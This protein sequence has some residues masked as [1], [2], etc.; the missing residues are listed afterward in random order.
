MA[1]IVLRRS[2]GYTITV[3][4][5]RGFDVKDSRFQLTLTWY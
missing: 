2:S 5:M 4:L 3:L 1:L